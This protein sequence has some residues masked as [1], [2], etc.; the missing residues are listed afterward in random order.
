MT[1][2]LMGLDEH[3]GSYAGLPLA[4]QQSAEIVPTMPVPTVALTR[5]PIP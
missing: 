2:E 1:T 3:I 4:N 5:S